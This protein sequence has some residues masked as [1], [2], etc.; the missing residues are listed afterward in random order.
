MRNLLTN[1]IRYGGETIRVSVQRIGPV[2]SVVVADNGEGVN[3]ADESAIFQPF[4]GGR[5]MK[6]VSGS[7]GL[8][9]WISLG[10]ARKMDGDLSYQRES[11]QTLFELILPAADIEPESYQLESRQTPTPRS[12]EYVA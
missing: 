12:T 5:T 8:G 9:L 3:P 2:I 6:A 7:S 1:A 11:G 4:R 10:L